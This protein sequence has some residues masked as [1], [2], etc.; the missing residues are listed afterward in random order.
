[1]LLKLKHFKRLSRG[2]SCIS[3]LKELAPRTARKV[4]LREKQC[5]KGTAWWDW[6]I[7]KKTNDL[8]PRCGLLRDSNS[9]LEVRNPKIILTKDSV[10]QIITSLALKIL[11]TKFWKQIITHM[12][13]EYKIQQA[14]AEEKIKIPNNN[15]EASVC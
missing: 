4:A 11:Y 1:M 3:N 7:K 10:Q 6:Q 8:N 9:H 12:H 13:T 15:Y 2:I 5:L 14:R